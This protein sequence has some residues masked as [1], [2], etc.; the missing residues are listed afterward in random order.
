M[1]ARQGKWWRWIVEKWAPCCLDR[2]PIPIL[3]QGYLRSGRRRVGVH[4]GGPG[5]SPG[6]PRADRAWALPA[7]DGASAT[8]RQAGSP[9]EIPPMA[10]NPASAAFR[11]ARTAPGSLLCLLPTGT[12]PRRWRRVRRADPRTLRAQLPTPEELLLRSYLGAIA[13][14]EN[15]PPNSIARMPIWP[16]SQAVTGVSAAA[17]GTADTPGT[18][19][20]TATGVTVGISASL[21]AHSGLHVGTS[22]TT[23]GGDSAGATVTT[24]TADGTGGFVTT[25]C[26]VT[27][28]GAAGASTTVTTD[29]ADAAASPVTTVDPAATGPSVTV[30]NL[31]RWAPCPNGQS[32]KIGNLPF[33]ATSRS[34]QPVALITLP[35][36]AI[37]RLPQ[38]DGLDRLPVRAICQGSQPD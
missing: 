16:N 2:G 5:P 22:V 9:S 23:G 31:S 19:G 25:G 27:A 38:P 12:P 15:C 30:G 13:A 1:G 20:T 21:I 28:G 6:K 7:A 17:T 3:I 24:A 14:I 29:T 18:T 8:Y 26:T 33:R 36:Q 11:L 37:W 4:G 32:V 10:C 35:L 34:W